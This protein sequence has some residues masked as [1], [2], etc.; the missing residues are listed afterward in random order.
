MTGLEEKNK[1]SRSVHRQMTGKVGLKGVTKFF[2]EILKLR[3]TIEPGDVLF[4]DCTSYKP[5]QQFKVGHRFVTR[6]PVW[7][8][9]Y[10]NKIFFLAQTT[11]CQRPYMERPR[12]YRKD[13]S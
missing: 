9:D 3:W 6:H 4:C 10:E 1:R 7:T 2:T 5:E 11:I 12:D 13:T 8:I